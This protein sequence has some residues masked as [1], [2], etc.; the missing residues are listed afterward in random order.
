MG[1]RAVK[2]I[3]SWEANDITSKIVFALA[4]TVSFELYCSMK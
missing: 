2:K 1:S 3:R 4:S